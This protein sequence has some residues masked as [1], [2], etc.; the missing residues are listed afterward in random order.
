LSED[1]D[2]A[3]PFLQPFEQL[4]DHGQFAAIIDEMF[5]QGIQASIFDAFKQIWMTLTMSKKFPCKTAAPE[6][7][8][9]TTRAAALKL[10]Q[11]FLNC[12]TMFRTAVRFLPEF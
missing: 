5:A 9:T 2:T 6:V 1:E 10:T 7:Q 8:C 4:V 11:H 3:T 12:M